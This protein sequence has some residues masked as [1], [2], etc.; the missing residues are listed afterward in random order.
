M[1][2]LGLQ[3]TVHCHS[4]HSFDGQLSYAQLR[5]FFI[6]RG[7][8]FACMTEHIEYLDQPKVDAIFDECEAHSDDRF[9]FVPGIEMDY[10]KIYLLGLDRARVDFASHRSQFDSLYPNA[11]MCVFSHPIKARYCYPQWLIE[12]CDAV[13]ILNTKHDGRHY[14]RPQSEHLLAQVRKQRPQAV[15][16][17]GMDFHGP[18][19]YSGV[20][21]VLRNDVSLT[22]EAVMEEIK[23]GHFDLQMNGRP[24]SDIAGWKR[25]LLRGR[26]HAMDV[27]HGINKRLARSGIR[28][29]YGIK[30]L[31]RRSMEGA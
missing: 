24:F 2:R 9:L 15:G 3:G 17:A 11:R 4:T 28:I 22:N 30:R 1:N 6:E 13:E 16:V 31:L 19:H 14:F 7:L 10:F 23:N 25:I 8:S 20:H 29:P 26:I 18:R 27:A 21:L 5:N 12:R